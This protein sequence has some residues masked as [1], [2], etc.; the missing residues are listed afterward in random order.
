[1]SL[2]IEYIDNYIKIYFLYNFHPLPTYI[3]DQKIRFSIYFTFPK[4]ILASNRDT[5]KESAYMGN[6]NE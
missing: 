6:K 1:M 5:E 2:K 3:F 4:V